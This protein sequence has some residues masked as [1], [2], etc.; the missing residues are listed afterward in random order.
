MPCESEVFGCWESQPSDSGIFLDFEGL[1]GIRHFLLLSFFLYIS[2]YSSTSFS[3]RDRSIIRIRVLSMLLSVSHIAQLEKHHCNSGPCIL[4]LRRCHV[5]LM[6][7][8]RVTIS[9]LVSS[10]IRDQR[11]CAASFKVVGSICICHIFPLMIPVF[12]RRSSPRLVRV[13]CR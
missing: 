9:R 7:L 1:D 11:D 12:L 13:R 8:R 6:G 5:S 2:L 3:S 10:I 4:A